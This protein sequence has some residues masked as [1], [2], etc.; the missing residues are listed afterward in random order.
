MPRL[1]W[2]MLGFVWLLRSEAA[3]AFQ[4]FIVSNGSGEVDI[5]MTPRV[6]SVALYVLSYVFRRESSLMQDCKCAHAML[7]RYT[8]RTEIES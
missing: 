2:S 7:T 4:A 5:P 8:A 1:W 3:K 6:E